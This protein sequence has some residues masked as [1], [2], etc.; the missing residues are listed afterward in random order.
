MKIAVMY[1]AATA[2]VIAL[3]NS[4]FVDLFGIGYE[5]VRSYSGF[6]PFIILGVG[7]YL[8]LKKTKETSYA[9][10]LNYGQ[11]IYSGIVIAA[12]IALFCGVINF[13]YFQF[14]NTDYSEEVIKVAMPLME[15]DKLKSDEIAVQL[16]KIRETYKPINQL[17]GTFVIM[18][19]AGIVFSAIFS[20]FFRTKDT[21]NLAPKD[22]E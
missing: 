3:V 17:T 16:E 2:L 19:I 8:G 9:N 5:F 12:F 4:F 6:S 13:F 10:E 21:F 7:L 1:G 15:K 20:A 18:L 11:A 14:I 22:K